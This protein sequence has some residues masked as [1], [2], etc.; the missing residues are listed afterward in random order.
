MFLAIEKSFVVL[1]SWNKFFENILVNAFL[2][3]DVFCLKTL[4]AA[5]KS[6][7][8]T[9]LVVAMFI[10][11]LSACSIKTLHAALKSIEKTQ[12]VVAMFIL[13]LSA[14]SIKPPNWINQQP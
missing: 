14:C 10:L 11:K 9:Q 5:L 12:L 6:I 13:K 4:H 3:T 2:S 7:E 8:K 1:V